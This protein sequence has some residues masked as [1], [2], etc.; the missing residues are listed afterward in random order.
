MAH[1]TPVSICQFPLVK[2]VRQQAVFGGDM[3][4]GLAIFVLEVPPIKIFWEAMIAKQFMGDRDPLYGDEV[5][6]IEPCRQRICLC[7]AI[8]PLIY[9]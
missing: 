5:P 3:G 2:A 1:R 7:G 8:S 9:S 4:N 6:L